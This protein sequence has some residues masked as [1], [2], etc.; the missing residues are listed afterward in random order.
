MAMTLGCVNLLLPVLCH[1]VSHCLIFRM[2]YTV[3]P[4]PH[5]AQVMSHLKCIELVISSSVPCCLMLPPDI[6]NRQYRQSPHIHV[7]KVSTILTI[8]PPA[9]RKVYWGRNGPSLEL[10][11]SA[12]SY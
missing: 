4:S 10:I 2:H 7:M 3:P 5:C 8:A 6:L 12:V 11:F 9:T 1:I